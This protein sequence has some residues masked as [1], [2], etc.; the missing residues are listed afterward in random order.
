MSRILGGGHLWLLRLILTVLSWCRLIL[1]LQFTT[2]V[3]RGLKGGDWSFQIP[4]IRNS[5]QQ[6][7]DRTAH[8][9]VVAATA[10]VLLEWPLMPP[11][12]L[13][14]WEL[15][16]LLDR[17]KA[18]QPLHGKFWPRAAEGEIQEAHQGRCSCRGA[19]RSVLGLWLKAKPPPGNCVM[20]AGNFHAFLSNGFC[21]SLPVWR[22]RFT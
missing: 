16:H 2:S 3:L 6:P 1:F 9:P 5:P 11:L 20:R 8:L 7:E 15:S 4:S 21:K 13:R 12:W 17:K 10:A 19:T 14:A 22:W 18:K